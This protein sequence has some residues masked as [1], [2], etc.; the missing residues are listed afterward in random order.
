TLNAG[1]TKKGNQNAPFTVFIAGTDEEQS[2]PSIYVEQRVFQNAQE[3][4]V[5]HELMFKGKVQ[6]DQE[7]LFNGCGDE[8][9]ELGKS[10]LR[11]RIMTKLFDQ[12]IRRAIYYGC[13]IKGCIWLNEHTICSELAH[14]VQRYDGLPPYQISFSAGDLETLLDAKPRG[15]TLTTD[16]SGV[17]LELIRMCFKEQGIHTEDNGHVGDLDLRVLYKSSS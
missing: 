9:L 5:V 16:A 10:D 2:N 1:V 12:Y 7:Y 14:K 17:G 11:L 8:D 13:D 4:F 3:K 6:I 15:S